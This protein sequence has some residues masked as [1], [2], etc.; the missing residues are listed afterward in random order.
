MDF[1]TKLLS[2]QLRNIADK[3]D[4]GNSNLSEEDLI[5]S[6]E[7]LSQGDK[8]QVMSK[9]EACK[10]MRMSRSTFDSYVQLG[11]IPKGK[12]Q[13]GLK[14]LTWNKMELEIAKHEIESR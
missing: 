5:K 7:I 8:T 10:L 13:V 3:L 4:A 1:L 2:S 6:L 14:E 12:K 9:E 11:L